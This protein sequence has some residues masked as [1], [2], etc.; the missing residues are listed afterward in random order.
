MISK[1]LSSKNIIN[2]IKPTIDEDELL[3]DTRSGFYDLKVY[4]HI[5]EH[6]LYINLFSE[7]ELNKIISICKKIPSQ[8]GTINDKTKLEDYR[9]STIAW[10]P[11]NNETQ[12]IYERLTRCI[13]E[14]NE[15]FFQYDLTRIEKLQF[16]NYFGEEGG[17]YAPHI[18]T[19]YGV[20]VDNR[21]LT[22]VLQLSNPDDYSGG[23]LR[24]HTTK[25]PI[26]I[27]KKK[28]LITFFPSHILHE[29]TPVTSGNRH[30]LVGWIH[31]PRFK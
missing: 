26:S 5:S 30:T 4:N 16:T 13:E 11:V 10:I 18:D 17:F 3:S 27:E 14:V 31:G 6:Y 28:G 2:Q 1:Y 9:K 20:M 22:F 15:E 24:L 29:C 19:S 25:N 7:F 12:W 23:E 21:K 8:T